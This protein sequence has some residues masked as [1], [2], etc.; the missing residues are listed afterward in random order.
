MRLDAE[1]LEKLARQSVPR[2]MLAQADC[3][4]A[5]RCQGLSEAKLDVEACPQCLVPPPRWP[6]RRP[7][8]CREP[9]VARVV[10][11]RSPRKLLPVGEGRPRSPSAASR[12]PAV[13]HG[14]GTELTV[15]GLRLKCK[16]MLG[17]GSFS[18]AGK[19]LFW[20][21]MACLQASAAGF[22]L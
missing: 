14:P 22:G 4:A 12:E 16:N 21:F 18:E 15:A 7:K 10:A 6:Q 13:K 1:A 3:R 20:G 8:R 2:A 19:V 11:G 17:R 5:P 9:S